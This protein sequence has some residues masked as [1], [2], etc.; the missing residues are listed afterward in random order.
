[1]HRSDIRRD[2]E[3]WAQLQAL[4]AAGVSLNEI[5]RTMGVDHRTV[6]RHFPD[7]KVFP[8]GWSPEG[9][10]IAR[11]TR[12]LNSIEKADLD[13]WGSTEWYKRTGKKAELRAEE[14]KKRNLSTY[15]HGTTAMYGW[16]RCRCDLCKEA[17]RVRT[18]ELR[19]NPHTPRYGNKPRKEET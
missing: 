10:E 19:E 6:K 13:F 14:F 17:A 12:A 8:Q 5:R 1:M 4:V 18:A 3:R 7:Y 11:T 15:T 2:P 16:G 9:Q